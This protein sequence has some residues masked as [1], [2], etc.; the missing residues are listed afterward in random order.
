MPGSES[1]DIFWDEVLYY[2]EVDTGGIPNISVLEGLDSVEYYVY[3]RSNLGS[4]AEPFVK[5]LSGGCS[6][7]IPGGTTFCT[8]SDLDLNANDYSYKVVAVNNCVT[9]E[10][11]EPQGVVECVGFDEPKLVISK[12]G[13]DQSSGFGVNAGDTFNVE[14]RYCSMMYDDWQDVI[15]ASITVSSLSGIGGPLNLDYMFEPANDEGYFVETIVTTIGSVPLPNYM[16]VA[17]NGDTLTVEYADAVI[18][19]QQRLLANNYF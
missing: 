19:G 5:I 3:R 18:S 16:Q 7:P 8:D 13:I 6:G 10:S 1:I 17:S 11:R 15:P 2:D 12:D 9:S 4:T 14:V